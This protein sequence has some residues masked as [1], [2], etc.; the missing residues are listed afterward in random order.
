[1]ECE[2]LLKHILKHSSEIQLFT[3]LF[4]TNWIDLT[5][6]LYFYFVVQRYMLLYACV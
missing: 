4:I 1:M 2:I 6:S 5:I 3:L